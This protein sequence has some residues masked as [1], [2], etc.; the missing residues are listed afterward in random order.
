[1]RRIRTEMRR[2]TMPNLSIPL[3]R[4]LRYLRDHPGSSLSELAD[5]LGLTMPSA[6]KL[7]QRLV[8]N[9]VVERRNGKDRRRLHLTLTEQGRVALALARLETAQQLEGSLESL[10]NQ[11]LTTVSAALSILG[12][13]FSTLGSRDQSEVGVDVNVP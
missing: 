1:M 11:E 10:S 3:L 5:A 9:K 12:Q 6:S 2:R 7:V 13:V 4:S 8:L